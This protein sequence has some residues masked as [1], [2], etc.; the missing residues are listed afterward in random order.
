MTEEHPQFPSALQALL[1][2][3]GLM[4]IETFVA[5]AVF[6]AE[7]LAGVND[8]DVY[9]FVTVVGNGILFVGLMAYKRIGY[10]ALFHP[11]K[12][13]VVAT[14]TLVS[15]PI[16]LMVP[17]LVFL[18]GTGNTIVQWL[19]PMTPDDVDRFEQMMAPGIVPVLF[20][21]LVAPVLEEMLFRGVILRGFLRRY[22]RTF[23]IPWSAALFGLAHLNLYQFATAFVIGIVGGWLY[24]RCRSLWPCILL[25]ATY[26]SFI[27]GYYAWLLSRT[28]AEPVGPGAVFL[29]ASFAGLIVGGLILLRL[30]GAKARDSNP[31]SRR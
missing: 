1:L 9:A 5:V 4:V 24:E 11:A 25:H 3:A 18:A 30:L 2:I 7:L 13:T 12:H 31:D 26:N 22:S 17:G 15:V 14:M 16:L 23:A 8:L 19:F 20:T 10:R 6:G 28:D 21:C 29:G 27:T